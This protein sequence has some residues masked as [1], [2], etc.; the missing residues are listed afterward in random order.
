MGRL[1]SGRES[2]MRDESSPWSSTGELGSRSRFQRPGDSSAALAGPPARLQRQEPVTTTN[3]LL[4]LRSQLE[5]AFRGERGRTL[6]AQEWEPASGRDLRNLA[7]PLQ[8]KVTRI[9]LAEGS[10]GGVDN[11]KRKSMVCLLCPGQVHDCNVGDCRSRDADK[12][13]VLRQAASD[14][15]AE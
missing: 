4:Q 10:C 3:S 12:D 7:L 9:G 15:H 6:L 5:G 1:S 11:A 8:E 2:L 13:I 14:G